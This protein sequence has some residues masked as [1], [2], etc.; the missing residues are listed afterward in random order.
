[1]ASACKSPPELLTC[2]T[3]T[4]PYDDNHRNAKFLACHHTFCSHCLNQWYTKNGQTDT[5]SIQCPNCKQL[6]IV[7]E[8]GIDGLQTNFYVESMK[9]ISDKYQ[10]LMEEP[11][12]ARSTD[13]CPEHGNQ[14]MFFFCET[15]SMAICRDCTVLDHKETEEHIAIGIKKA[16]DNYRHTLEE[17]LLK[18]RV[19]QDEIQSTIQEVES[20]IEAIQDDK[21]LVTENLVVFIQYAQHELNQF[22]QRATDAISEDHSIH[23]EKLMGKKWQFQQAKGLLDKHISQAEQI[24]KSD[25]ISDILSSK[26]QL[27]KVTQITKSNLA[28]RRSGF[29]S[30]LISFPNLLNDR[31]HRIGKTCL[32]SFLPTRVVC[33]N[34]EIT[35]GLKSVI[36]LELFNDAGN[37]FLFAASF[38]T[39]QIIDP[40]KDELKTTLNTSYPDCTVVF[41]PQV[42]GRHEISIMCLG[43]KLKSE[44]T[45]IMVNSNNPVIK[46]GKRGNDKGTF[47]VPWSI[48]KD[49][50]GVLYVADRGNRLIQKFSDKGEFI[51]QFCVNNIDNE[52]TTVD[53]AFDQHNGLIYC[54]E[55]Q[56]KGNAFYPRQIML[57]FNLDGELQH[58]C[59]LSNSNFPICI[60]INRQ[61]D[62]IISDITKKCLCKYDKQGK[63]L[64]SMG[65]L[66]CPAFITIG[67]DDCI[68]V[69]DRDDDCICIFNPDGTVRHTFRTSGTGKGQLRRP[70]GV[71]TDGDLIL[72]ADSGNNRIQVFRCDGTF[73][74]M[75]E[76]K[77]DPLNTPMGLLIT[78]DGYVYVADMNHH[79]IKKYKYK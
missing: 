17:Q 51:T 64:G 60:A 7:P 34:D 53:M 18:S 27:E 37:T 61:Q 19:T 71:A 44:Q 15:C 22:Q 31:L 30:D 9:E 41:T 28:Q 36:T 59:N 11:K 66:K 57:A 72:V 54:V 6:T 1:M 43:N 68:I 33:K 56:Y 16:T 65:F 25:N 47:N 42:S 62:I 35:A 67:E 74:S 63:Y 73:V 49:N 58:T 2:T 5:G 77:D 3:C 40:H 23:H 10:E 48:A 39:I 75:I 55:L 12:L 78:G 32:K 8:N 14:P 29:K 21:D 52:C 46:F 50:N 70:Y 26:S 20:E 24:T 69:A 79:C 13:G 76:S 45:H 38:L 4:K